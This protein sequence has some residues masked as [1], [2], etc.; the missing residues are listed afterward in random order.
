MRFFGDQLE[1]NLICGPLNSL[2]DLF[3]LVVTQLSPLVRDTVVNLP[4]LI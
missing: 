2:I 1:V 3:F 4:E